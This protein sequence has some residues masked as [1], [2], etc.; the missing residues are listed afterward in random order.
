MLFAVLC[1]LCA[2][3]AFVA[4][5]IDRFS[6]GLA[7]AGALGPHEDRLD[8]A[9]STGGSAG[10]PPDL[11]DEQREA[12]RALCAPEVQRRALVWLEKLGVPLQDR[13]DVLQQALL[14]AARSI[15][16]FDPARGSAVRWFN[17]IVCHTA[18]DYHERTGTRREVLDEEPGIDLRDEVASADEMLVAEAERVELLDLLA[19]LPQRERLLIVQHDLRGV[20]MAEL[21]AE[22]RIAI[23]TAYHARARGLAAL[24]E[25]ARALLRR[26]RG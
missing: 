13:R 16:T 22:H 11:T 4:V 5:T 17:Q 1:L 20:S 2:L 3:W 21:A 12:L 8:V 18:S 15:R 24:A 14:E 6:R 26:Q 9:F 10:G 25:M 7:P 19:R 23:P